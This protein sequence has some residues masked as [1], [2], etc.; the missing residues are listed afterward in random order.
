MTT[1]AIC[2]CGT[3]KI[4]D[5]CCGPYISGKKKAPTAEALMRSR[6]TAYTINNMNYIAETHDSLTGGDFDRESAEKWALGSE[7]LGLDIK[8]V[9]DG[10]E[11]D[12]KGIVEFVAR[13]RVDGQEQTHHEISQFRRESDRWV[14]VDGKI[15][16][17]P[18]VRSEP[19]IGRNDP[20]HCGSGKKFKKCHAA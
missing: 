1:Q 20:C 13:Y 9:K 19:K 17:D 5:V 16:R 18:T 3:Q 4:L 7:W 6:Y 2:P 8:S 15:V 10:T 11:G 14:F 12:D